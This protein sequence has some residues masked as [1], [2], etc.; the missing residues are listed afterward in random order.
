MLH[1][2]SITHCTNGTSIMNPFK[3]VMYTD[4]FWR[5]VIFVHSR[6]IYMGLECSFSTI[7]PNHLS[8]T[9]YMGLECINFFPDTSDTQY[10]QHM[11]ILAINHYRQ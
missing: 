6:L 8:Y 10:E 2:L 3:F 7:C 9:I 5:N 11:T 4:V 1:G